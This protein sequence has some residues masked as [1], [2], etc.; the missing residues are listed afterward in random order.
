MCRI[1]AFDQ[2]NLRHVFRPC[3]RVGLPHRLTAPSASPVDPI[4]GCGEQVPDPVAILGSACRASFRPPRRVRTITT[5]TSEGNTLLPFHGPVLESSSSNSSVSRSSR[6]NSSRGWSASGNSIQGRAVPPIPAIPPATRV[7]P[8]SHPLDL[9]CSCGGLAKGRPKGPDTRDRV[10]RE[11]VRTR[12]AREFRQL[13]RGWPTCPARS[14]RRGC[15]GFS[16]RLSC[17]VKGTLEKSSVVR[18]CVDPPVT[19]FDIKNLGL[20]AGSRARCRA[21]SRRQPPVCCRSD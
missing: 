5:L 13:R 17:E 2:R 18:P 19:L 11:R 4:F 15:P 1:S 7:E 3:C 12:P 6:S 10:R 9:G 16:Y 14:Q 8:R 21:S 20:W